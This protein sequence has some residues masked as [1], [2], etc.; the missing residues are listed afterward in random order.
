MRVWCK[1]MR[2]RNRSTSGTATLVRCFRPDTGPKEPSER[3]RK[4][5][6]ERKCDRKHE[7]RVGD[8]PAGV[9]KLLPALMN[10]RIGR[11][12]REKEG[13][14]IANCTNRQHQRHR[15]SSDCLTQRAT[16]LNFE[17][18]KHEPDQDAGN[19]ADHDRIPI[20]PAYRRPKCRGDRSHRRNQSNESTASCAQSCL[21]WNSAPTQHPG[22]EYR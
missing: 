12:N 17:N 11:V 9:E 16:Q 15:G 13:R 10:E 18:R 2:T 4:I 3:R 22:G 14:S 21:H 20:A 19:G 1:V 5:D 7:S 8:Q 6:R